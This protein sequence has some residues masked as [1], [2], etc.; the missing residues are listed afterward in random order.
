MSIPSF[1]PTRYKA[2]QRREWGVSADSWKRHWN[3]WERAAQRLNERLV[4]L[5]QIRAGH[6]VLDVATGLGE[7]AFTAARRVGPNGS[8]VAT[9]LSPAM[10]SLAREEAVRRGLRNVEFREMDAE[11]PDLPAQ[12]F[13]A[14]LCRWTL[15]FLPHL[16]AALTRLRELLVPAGRFAAAVW[17][18]PENV[19]FTSVP[20]GVIGRVLRLAAPPAGTPGTFSLA[21]EHVLERSFTQAGFAEVAIERQ[22]LT[23]EYPSLE[24]FIEE[25]PATSASIRIMLA[26]ASAVQRETIWQIVA[27]AIGKY[28]DA[29]GVLRIPT[30]T[31][32]VVGKA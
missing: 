10:L 15:M 4:D 20:M 23:F 18:S 9:D 17:G 30:E 2:A 1:D 25:R 26:E 21:D 6:R 28:Q 3:I 12:S 29:A 8:V 22:T 13:D 7:P 24:K 11:A 27:E 14:A 19:P 5:A 31:L 16:I 32:C